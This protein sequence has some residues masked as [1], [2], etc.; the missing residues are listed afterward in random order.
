MTRWA[1]AISLGCVLGGCENDVDVD[2]DAAAPSHESITPE[3][4][5]TRAIPDT[6]IVAEAPLDARLTQVKLP[7]ASGSTAAT[8]R[9]GRENEHQGWVA[10]LPGSGNLLTVAYGNGRVYVS[11]GLDSNAMYAMDAKTG[12]RLWTM[13]SMN[14]PGPTAPTFEDDELAF[15]TYSCTMVMVDA[16][17]GKARWQLWTGSETPNQPAMI[18]KLVIAPHPDN[19]GGYSLSAYTKKNGTHVWSSPIDGHIINAPIIKDD[20]VYVSTANGTLYK[21]SL[22][23]KAQWHKSIGATSAPWI[24]GDEVHVTTRDGSKEASIVLASADGARLRT[25]AKS[26]T[27]SESPG[28]EAGSVF[29]YDGARPVVRDGV[30]YLAIGGHVE[31]RDARTDKLIWTRRHGKGESSRQVNS[32]AVAGSL[33]VVTSRDG[34]VVAL[35]RATGAQRIGYSFGTSINTQPIVAEGWMYVATNRGQ[36]LAFDLGIGKADGWTQWGGNAQ[37]NL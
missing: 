10:Q 22:D 2:P 37:H 31:A 13:A 17:T 4:K 36:V 8:F 30:A 34:E 6:P 28:D 14:D 27:P 19:D 35:D 25:V 33:V 7:K 5:A 12:K 26:A 20:A 18:G 1:L 3:S 24:D 23:G 29:N 32:V 15:N 11:G 16:R 9:F 21:V